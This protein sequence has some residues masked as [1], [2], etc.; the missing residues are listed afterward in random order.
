MIK[1][2]FLY[3]PS[4]LHAKI[5]GGVQICSQDFLEI[6]TAAVNELYHFKVTYSTSLTFKL[7]Y[8]I[9]SN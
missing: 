7:L 5:P 9:I 8:K 3:N 1:G 2:L 6:L 4:D